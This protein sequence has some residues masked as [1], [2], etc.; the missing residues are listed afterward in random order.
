[1]IDTRLF[2]ASDYEWEI[3]FK[4]RLDALHKVFRS[5]THSTIDK[6]PV[7]EWQRFVNLQEG[8]LY[9]SC[10][11][12]TVG[13]GY[14]Y[15]GNCGRLVITPLT[16]R[17]QRSIVLALKHRYGSAL[18]GPFGTGKTETVKDLSKTLARSIHVI[19]TSSQIDYVEIL[20]FF[21]GVTSSGAWVLFDEL[22][23]LEVPMMNFMTQIISQIQNAL[24]AHTSYIMVE[25]SKIA[26]DSE[27]AI[28]ITLNPG[29][30]GR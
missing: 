12:L 11:N 21:K 23:R 17:A 2:S 28:F 16:E 10:F 19:N 15:V 22:N 29:Y 1:M 20:K 18:E 6:K 3:Q 13:Y 5:I 8:S 25:E 24:R 9:L 14:E 27:S 4:F 7:K 30:A 26:I